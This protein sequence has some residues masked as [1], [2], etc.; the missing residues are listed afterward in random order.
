M[1]IHNN[2]RGVQEIILANGTVFMSTDSD[3]GPQDYVLGVGNASVAFETSDGD[4]QYLEKL[5]RE[6]RF[7]FDDPVEE[8]SS[9]P[10]EATKGDI[11]ACRVNHLPDWSLSGKETIQLLISRQ[12]EPCTIHFH[13]TLNVPPTDEARVVQLKI[14]AHRAR[15][16]LNVDIKDMATGAQSRH[17]I[18][19]EEGFK[20]GQLSHG[21]QQVTVPLQAGHN[22][23]EVS[24]SVDFHS[25]IDDGQG[26]VPFIFLSDIVEKSEHVPSETLMPVR[27][28]GGSDKKGGKWIKAAVPGY[29]ANHEAIEVITGGVSTRIFDPADNNVRMTDCYGHTIMLVADRSTQ[30]VVF[31]NGEPVGAAFVGTND[32]PFRVPPNYLL[33]LQAHVAIKDLSGTQVFEEKLVILPKTTTPNDIIQ[34]ETPPPYDFG[35]FAQTM[36]RYE[37][38]RLQMEK[39]AKRADFEALSHALKTLEGGYDR[40]KLKPLRFPKVSKP[41]VSV[42]IPVHNKVEVTYLALCSLLLAHNEC[43]FEVIVVDDGSTD[44]T[45]EL[46]T[47]VSGIQV[48]HNAEALRF[49]GACNAGVAKAKGEYVALLNNDVEVTSGWLDTLLDAFERFPDV[50]LVGSKLLYPD[51]RL[52]DAGG[53]IW[54]SGN[55]WN[56]GNSQNPNHP[57]FCYTRQADYLS[58]AAMMTTLKIWSEVGGLSDYLKPMYFEDTDFAFKIRDAGYRTYFVPG[59]KVFHYEGMTSGT[60]VSSGFKRF[61]EVNRPKFKR[62]WA[63]AFRAFG[64]EGERPDLEKDRGIRGRVLFIDYTTPRPDQDAGSYAAIQEMKLVQSLGYKVTFLPTNMA[65]LGSYTEELGKMGIEA[66]HA[67][68]YMTMSEYLEQHAMDFDAF[69][70]T[71]YYVAEDALDHI[72]KYAPGRKVLFNNAD[73]HFLRQFRA[74]RT[75]NDPE[76]LVEAN[77]T[78][79]KELAIIERSDVIL[80]YNEV[81]H[82]VIEAY[83][84]GLA[85]IAKCP[86]VVD[87]ADSC[88]GVKSRKGLSFVGGFRHHPNV[89]GIKWFAKEVMPVVAVKDPSIELSIYGSGMGDDVR[90]LAASKI[91]PVG[92]VEDLKDAHDNHRIFVAPLLSGAGIKGKVLGALASGLPCV[93]SPVAAEGIGLRSG[94]DCF[95]VEKPEDWADAIHRLNTDNALWKSMSENALNYMRDGY[96]FEKGRKMMKIAFEA[97]ELF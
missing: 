10:E 32:T 24:F 2:L 22:G 21:Y 42:V 79:D 18:A 8:T 71:R 31:I 61:Q 78:R 62:R 63:D 4:T 53:I 5:N 59:S 89:E 97:A 13:S 28:Y 70:L 23:L 51:G 88:P 60:D 57:S 6:N 92:F 85:T 9:T 55:P 14:A 66:I 69:Y 54:G 74:A 47:L 94:H 50:G 68:F 84:A 58:G 16:T 30:S 20:G 17:Q 76:L 77:Q 91:K 75:E 52:Q 96:S 27:M 83:T 3:V 36:D 33:G 90:A 44:E 48:I 80:S 95:I 1:R 65:H 40:V 73:L 72:R 25:Y 26:I 46:E 38:M 67:P 45:A 86:W 37:S 41:D 11:Y 7:T 49:I 34:R 12:H 39:N 29:L 15:A 87:V 93:L 82:S 56:Y 35:N 81:E 43:S 64:K 19:F